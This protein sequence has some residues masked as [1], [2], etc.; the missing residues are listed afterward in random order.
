MSMLNDEHQNSFHV[1][2][3]QSSD[4][5]PALAGE[6][7]ASTEGDAGAG[8]TGQAAEA[9]GGD[10]FLF[11]VLPLILM[12][13][14]FSVFGGRKEKKKRDALMASIKKHDRVRTIGGVIGSIVE[15]KNDT[16]LLKVDESSNTRM[17][18]SRDAVQQVLDSTDATS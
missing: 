4:G 6:G 12:M 17:T 15:V 18:F 3:A 7:V 5:G 10:L 11:M 1:L 16:V 13:I 2:L 9:A 14:A 8:A